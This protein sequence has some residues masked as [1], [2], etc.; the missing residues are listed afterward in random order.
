MVVFTSYQ[1]D[2]IQLESMGG[3]LQPHVSD[4]RMECDNVVV[5]MVVVDHLMDDYS[6]AAVLNLER[7]ISSFDSYFFFVFRSIKH[8]VVLI[9]VHHHY[10]WNPDCVL[11]LAVLMTPVEHWNAV[12]T[13]IT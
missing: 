2:H 3:Y 6:S 11:V 7:L 12:D 13:E 10:R 5:P 9:L 1:P 4:D 8:V